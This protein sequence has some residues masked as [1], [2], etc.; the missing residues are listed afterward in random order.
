M[1]SVLAPK[2]NREKTPTGLAASGATFQHPEPF[3][4]DLPSAGLTTG[5]TIKAWLRRKGPQSSRLRLRSPCPEATRK[6]CPDALW[7]YPSFGGDSVSTKAREYI[8]YWIENSVHAAE[9]FGHAGA[10]QDVAEL[11]RR[12][13]AMAKDQ[14]ISETAI[15]DEVGDIADYIRSKLGV[16]NRTE[17]DRHK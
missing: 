7:R 10:S 13:I 4:L 2:P 5:A 1:L 3:V 11:A 8:D 14:G 12:C 16:A 15:A 17:K 6:A 9:Q